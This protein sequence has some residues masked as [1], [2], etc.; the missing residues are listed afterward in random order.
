MLVVINT[1]IKKILLRIRT[2]ENAEGS[3]EEREEEY[4]E[5]LEIVQV[6]VCMFAH[7]LCPHCIEHA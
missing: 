6:R 5:A 2:A 1:I 4:E 7:S 3:V